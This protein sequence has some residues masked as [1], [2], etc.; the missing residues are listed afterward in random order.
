MLMNTNEKNKKEVMIGT[1][2]WGPGMNGSKL[3]FGK[4][5][6][7]SVLRDTFEKATKLGFLK[8]DTAAVYGMGSCEKLLGGFINGRK[9]I[10]LSTKYFP[11]KKYKAGSLTDSFNE[12]M[13]RLQLKSA[14]IFWLHAP[15]NIEENLSE[16]VPLMKDGRI[17]SIGISSVSMENIKKAERYLEKNGLKLGAVQNHF[18]LLRNDQQPIIDYCNSKG[19]Q[20]YA[21]MVLEQGALT[22]RYNAKNHFPTFSMR[23]FAFPKSKFKKIEDLL[24]LMKTIANKYGIDESQI[25]ILWAIAKGAIPIIG[26]TKPAYAEKLSAALEVT[27]SDDEVNKL[28]AEAKKTGIRQQGSWEPQ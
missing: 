25:P 3:V 2:A 8:W 14:D 24:N 1:W 27:L 12:S 6:D 9:D 13:E 22:G 21:Y 16:A 17:K 28:T 4:S 19:I 15:K 5:Y 26:I 10:F 18:S 11:T 7:E 23:G 20:Y